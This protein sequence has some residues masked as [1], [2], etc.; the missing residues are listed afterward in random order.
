MIEIWKQHLDKGNQVGVVLMHL[1]KTFDTINHSFPLA[2][3]EANGFSANFLK[4]FQIS[5][6]NQFQRT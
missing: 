6:S 3:L 1:L 5:V 2:K 4:L